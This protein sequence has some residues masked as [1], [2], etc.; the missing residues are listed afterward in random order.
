MHPNKLN[1]STALRK[2]T[3][4]NPTNIKLEIKYVETIKMHVNY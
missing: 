3:N 4:Q 1:H 2:S